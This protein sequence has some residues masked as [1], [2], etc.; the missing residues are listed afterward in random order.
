MSAWLERACASAAAEAN[1]GRIMFAVGAACFVVSDNIL[2]AYCFGNK[3]EQYMNSAI[4]LTYYAAQ[5]LIGLSMA[6]V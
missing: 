2:C 5:L 4:H 6:F 3:R 1:A